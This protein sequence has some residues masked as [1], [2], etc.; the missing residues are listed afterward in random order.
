MKYYL[1]Y[2]KKP[3]LRPFQ[4][5]DFLK[6]EHLYCGNSC[7]FAWGCHEHWFGIGAD[8]VPAGLRP[9]PILLPWADCSMGTSELIGEDP[10]L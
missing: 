1:K 2:L 3:L 6:V 7:I 4:L 5:K 10:L 8:A 9:G